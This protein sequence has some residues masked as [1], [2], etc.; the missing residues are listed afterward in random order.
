M[1]GPH[2][3]NGADNFQM[4]KLEASGSRKGVVVELL[5]VSTWCKISYRQER[6]YINTESHHITLNEIMAQRMSCGFASMQSRIVN[7]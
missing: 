5:Y 2:V 6:K 7:H 3:K 1:R 4:S